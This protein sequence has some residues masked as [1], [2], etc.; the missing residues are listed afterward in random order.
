[1]DLNHTDVDI[2]KAG[3]E[4]IAMSI[5]EFYTGLGK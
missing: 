1:L 4:G 5:T 3:V 2:M